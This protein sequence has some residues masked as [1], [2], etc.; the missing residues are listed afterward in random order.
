MAT[1]KSP[2][3]NFGV[4]DPAIFKDAK[5]INAAAVLAEYMGVTSHADT[6]NKRKCCIFQVPLRNSTG[7][8]RTKKNP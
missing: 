1:L 5:L 2:V 4:G 6:M 8:W 7:R 3:F